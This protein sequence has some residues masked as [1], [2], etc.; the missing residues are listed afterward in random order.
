M[1]EGEVDTDAA[2]LV[3]ARQ[4][5][6]A[7]LAELKARHTPVARRLALSYAR[8]GVSADEIVTAAF[9]QLV[10]PSDRGVAANESFRAYLFVK[11]RRAATSAARQ[12]SEPVPQGLI[13]L[14]VDAPDVAP[15][16]NAREF[17]S[18]SFDELSERHQVALWHAT[19][20]GAGPAELGKRL[21]L[22]TDGAAA[23]AYRARARSCGRATSARG[24]TRRHSPPAART[25]SGSTPSSGARS[26]IAT[27]SRPRRTS[28]CAAT[29][30]RSSTSC[31]TCRCSC[32]GPRCR[33]SSVSACSPGCRR[34]RRR[35]SAPSA[36]SA[37]PV[38]GSRPGASA[39]CAGAAP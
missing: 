18:R 37:R 8:P 4:G 39:R 23:V 6:A 17:I 2:L 12:R 16:G 29:A 5:D 31:P 15:P 33:S 38:S 9:T 27:A 36:P 35:R 28:R 34:S 11:V 14:T 13:D 3:A 7:A 10:N 26:S 30:G 19:V 25:P 21:H 22:S 1:D 20:E 24:S 32:C